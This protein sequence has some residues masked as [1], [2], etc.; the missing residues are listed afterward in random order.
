MTEYIAALQNGRNVPKED[1]IF[2]ISSRAK[3]MAAEKG[4]EAVVNATIG[5]LLDD[6]GNLMVLS[7]VA[8][9]FSL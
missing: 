8:E 5:T 6:E 2:G 1:K 4:D 7:S 9:T 3:A